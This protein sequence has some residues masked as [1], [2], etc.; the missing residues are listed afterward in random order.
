MRLNSKLPGLLDIPEGFAC[1]PLQAGSHQSQTSR[2]RPLKHSSECL[3]LLSPLHLCDIPDR[4]PITEPLMLLHWN[5]PPHIVIGYK[6]NMNSILV[7]PQPLSDHRRGQGTAKVNITN[8]GVNGYRGVAGGNSLSPEGPGEKL[9]ARG[10]GGQRHCV[11]TIKHES[12]WRAPRLLCICDI[13]RGRK[14]TKAL[15]GMRAS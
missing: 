14:P 11:K 9:L 5:S 7:E 12:E 4:H 3:W 13:C 8:D 2:S 1:L 10:A 15:E 6:L